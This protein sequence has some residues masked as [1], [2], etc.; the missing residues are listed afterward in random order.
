MELGIVNCLLLIVNC[1][2]LYNEDTIIYNNFFIKELKGL[3]IIKKE[4]IWNRERL[5]QILSVILVLS[6]SAVLIWQKDR[7]ASLSSYGYIG[8]FFVSL[9]GSS[10][11]I[12]PLPS[13]FL[14]F[15]CGAIFNPL[16]VGIISGVGAS[17]GEITGYML[18]YGGRIAVDKNRYY[19][20]FVIWMKKWGGFT[21]FTLALIPNPLFDI[22]GA[23]AGMLKYS[24]WKF[25]LFGLLGRLPKHI[26]F[27]FFGYWFI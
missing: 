24:L 6:L 3:L 14:V 8:I 17:I 18:G 11:I 10:S 9:L 20:K 22:A 13:L 4:N 5:Y 19:E 2:Y 26:F 16:L 21:I 1:L 27:A 7:L 23:V 25:M 15:T 12:L